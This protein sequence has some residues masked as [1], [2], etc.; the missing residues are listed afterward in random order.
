MK[1]KIDMNDLP[2][3]SLKEVFHIF[4][5]YWNSSYRI[6]NKTLDDINF[7][8]IVSINDFIH[9]IQI[10]KFINM[11][12]LKAQ[13]KTNYLTIKINNEQFTW[14][15]IEKSLININQH[16]YF[17]LKKN[18]LIKLAMQLKTNKLIFEQVILNP[19]IKFINIKPD[20]IFITYT[21]HGCFIFLCQKIM[22]KND[23][24]KNIENINYFHPRSIMFFYE[25]DK[26]YQE[27]DQHQKVRLE[28][29]K[30]VQKKC[31]NK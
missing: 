30:L 9:F 8:I 24:Q 12:K 15:S 17:I 18:S 4:S 1:H 2:S 7:N 26:K 25:N 3:M 10:D 14:E 22:C 13:Q 28:I 29:S 20:I 31:G 16:K 6:W 5:K 11:N 19:Q 23:C 21:A 27:I